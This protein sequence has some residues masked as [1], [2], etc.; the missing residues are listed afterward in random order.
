MS[1]NLIDTVEPQRI[2]WTNCIVFGLLHAGAIAAFF[3][4]G[5]EYQWKRYARFGTPANENAVDCL[6]LSEVRRMMP[7]RR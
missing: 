5:V 3:M 4:L 1:T 6:A 7:R 2:N